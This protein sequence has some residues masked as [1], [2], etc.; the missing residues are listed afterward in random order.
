M[1]A[2]S[3]LM[4]IASMAGAMTPSSLMA[5]DGDDGPP[6]SA[7]SAALLGS[8]PAAAAP[9]SSCSSSSSHE[10]IDEQLS[11]ISLWCGARIR[12]ELLLLQL[13]A[14]G[15]RYSD[16]GGPNQLCRLTLDS[17]AGGVPFR[18]EGPSGEAG[19][20]GRV[21][22]ERDS[23]S[24]GTEGRGRSTDIGIHSVEVAM[25]GLSSGR[26]PGASCL[27]STSESPM[28]FVARVS[29]VFFADAGAVAAVKL[30]LQQHRQEG[31][32]G[33]GRRRRRRH[34]GGLPSPEA[35]SL[36][37]AVVGAAFPPPQLRRAQHGDDAASPPSLREL[38]FLQLRPLAPSSSDEDPVGVAA[39]GCKEEGLPA[40]ELRYSFAEGHSA[41][42]LMQ[43]WMMCEI[44]PGNITVR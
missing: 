18:A 12:W 17:L 14:L 31:D 7:A 25:A 23:R 9:F 28:G 42:D 6:R 40:L 29:G 10:G 16:A 19:E 4:R 8:S 30:A 11:R 34:G 38:P 21:G 26:G 22:E 27:P 36:V 33:P 41:Q 2:N 15:A 24:V 1:S 39:G 5:E 3:S 44:V 20:E 13:Q 37:Q 43:V 35:R 32:A